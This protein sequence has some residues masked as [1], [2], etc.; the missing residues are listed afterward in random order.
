[1]IQL[2][3]VWILGTGFLGRVE[4][5]V[6][7]AKFGVLTQ[8][9]QANIITRGKQEGRVNGRGATAGPAFPRQRANIPSWV[10]RE[11]Q[12]RKGNWKALFAASRCPPPS[13]P[14]AS[15]GKDQGLPLPLMQI[16]EASQSPQLK[17]DPQ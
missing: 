9:Q 17:A 3:E 14:P 8:G 12:Q 2:S 5:G 11:T 7:C 4:L 6:L 13:H 1:M 10:R 15:Q 16:F